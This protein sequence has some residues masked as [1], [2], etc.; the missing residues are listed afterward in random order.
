MTEEFK[1]SIIRR[2]KSTD[3]RPT[4]TA[5]LSREMEISSKD[6]PVFKEALDQLVEAGKVIID[7][8]GVVELRPLSGRIVGTFRSNPRG[9][10]FVLPLEPDLHEDLFIPPDNTA[11]ALNGDMV[12]ASVVTMQRRGGKTL[13][14]GKITEILQR[15]DSKFVG[16]LRHTETGWLVE[17]D[18]KSFTDPITVDDVTAKGA[19]DK[20]KVVVEMITRP[21]DKHRAQG[22]IIQVLG[23]AG[24]F[25]TELNSIIYKYHLPLE[26]A[27]DC[28]EQARHAAAIFEKAGN[29]VRQDLTGKTIITIDPPDARDFDDAISLERDDDNNFCLGVHIADVSSFIAPGTPLDNEARQRGNSV[30]LPGKVLPMLPE[31]LSNGICSLQPNQR[32]FTKSV[33]I[34]YDEL[35]RPIQRHFANSV[36]CSTQRLTYLQAD[37]ALKGHKKEVL[38]AVFELLKNM[39]TLSRLIE[40]RRNED[41]MLHLNL[42]ET[43]LILDNAGR[44][45][46]A[47]PAEAS[48]PHTII[49]MFMV[50][51]N[52]A[53]ASLLDRLN[54]PFIRRIHP[55]PD[56]MAMKELAIVMRSIGYNLPKVPDRYDLQKILASVVGQ[57]SEL[58]VNLVVLRSL[59]KARYSPQNVGHFALASRHYS[60]FTSPIRRYA[61]LLIHRQLDEYLRTGSLK[62]DKQ[63]DLVEAGKHISFTEERAQDAE[64]ELKTVLILQMLSKKIGEVMDCAITGLTNFGVFARSKKFGIEGL[65]TTAD[66][67]DDHWQYNQKHHCITGARSG[68]VLTLGKAIKAKIIAVNVAARQL[69]LSPAEALVKLPEKHKKEPKKFHKKRHTKRHSFR[70]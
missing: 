67:G 24:A 66:L 54:V 37:K 57:D 45:I 55:Q 21:T 16:T 34:T 68:V 27:E 50:E 12:A 18:G 59:E 9:F 60:H 3:Y 65:I 29:D 69:N 43:E 8:G 17:P 47:E 19:T 20:D 62:E 32:R 64:G 4:K 63:L 14:R 61:D 23:R 5:K 15:A 36:I 58:A 30:Y 70:R 41:G 49:E 6:Y 40:K 22:V 56:A 44:V 28:V 10:G 35:G 51:A 48:Y 2:L 52:E 38:P 31:M 7:R 1:K 42:P 33:F 26:F 53:V 11:D 13:Y 25:E 39:E 46:D